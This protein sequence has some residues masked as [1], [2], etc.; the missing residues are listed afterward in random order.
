LVEGWKAAAIPKVWLL[1]RGESAPPSGMTGLLAAL[2]PGSDRLAAVAA[3]LDRWL[4]SQWL[5]TPVF[6]CILVG[7]G[8][9]RKGRTRLGRTAEL[10]R[11]VTDCVVV[12]GPGKVPDGMEGL[13]RL[14]GAPGIPGPMAAVL[15]AT[16]WAPHVSWLIA[17]HD[18][19]CLSPDVLQ[20]LLS[21]RAP[22][23]WATL[24]QLPEDA[25]MEPALA[26]YDFRARVLVED[27]LAARDFRLRHLARSS[28]VI[29][30]SL[31][32]RSLT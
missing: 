11:S 26:H 3:L 1:K 19:T 13:P 21:T 18:L 8:N 12:A 30:Q 17:A 14:P 5:K 22:G 2:P 6:G 7:G 27:L 29:A 24:L 20:R 10:L 9:D 25:E 32:A 4:S 16:R 31:D 15:S 28:K 23:V